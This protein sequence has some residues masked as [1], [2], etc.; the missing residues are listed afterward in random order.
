MLLHSTIPK[1]VHGGH[2]KNIITP[3]IS[4]KTPGIIIIFSSTEKLEPCTVG[5]L[6][7][8]QNMRKYL[9][10]LRGLFNMGPT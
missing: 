4:K 8:P 6:I 7:W 10:Q 3:G 9:A 1:K 2:N 5:L